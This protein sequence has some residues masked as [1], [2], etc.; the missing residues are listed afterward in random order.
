MPGKLLCRQE[1]TIQMQDDPGYI[2]LH[3]DCTEDWR[4]TAQGPCLTSTVPAPHGDLFTWPAAMEE[5]KVL[6][7]N[8]H[9]QKRGGGGRMRRQAEHP[10]AEGN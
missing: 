7:L 3:A 5:A 1:S 6:G 10:L 8:T 2:P 4:S 9:G